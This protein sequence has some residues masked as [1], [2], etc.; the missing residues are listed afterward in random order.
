MRTPE[1]YEPLGGGV[2]ERARNE[3]RLGWRSEPSADRL[4]AE[5]RADRLDLKGA[6]ARAA[7]IAVC[8]SWRGT[9]AHY[10][11]C[12]REIDPI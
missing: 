10:L 11:L 1:S 6:E 7:E 5:G 4:E 8:T 3:A 2:R 9:F 12:S